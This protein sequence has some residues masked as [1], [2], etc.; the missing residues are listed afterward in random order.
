MKKSH[1][2]P[3]T[4]QSNIGVVSNSGITDSI[5]ET[6]INTDAQC[7]NITEEEIELAIVS[8]LL[9]LQEDIGDQDISEYLEDKRNQNFHRVFD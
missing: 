9:K 1:N 3:L 5:L 8:G 2:N 7:C 6:F 4:G